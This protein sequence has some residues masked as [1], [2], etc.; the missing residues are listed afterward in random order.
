MNWFVRWARVAVPCALCLACGVPVDDS[1]YEVVEDPPTPADRV[2]SAFAN[3]SDRCEACLRNSCTHAIDPCVDTPACTEFAECVQKIGSPAAQAACSSQDEDVTLDT[4][5]AFGEMRACW[6]VSCKAACGVGKN[7][8]CLGKYEETQPPRPV[9]LVRQSF[10]NMCTNDRLRGAPVAFCDPTGSCEEPIL[11]DDSGSYTFE[12]PTPNSGGLVGWRGFRSVSG[13]ELGVP[14]RLTRNLPIWSDQVE[15]TSLIAAD[16]AG[17][18]ANDLG[19]TDDS[20]AAL[21]WMH[22]MAV[23]IF[24][25]QATGADGVVLKVTTAPDAAIRYAVTLGS[26]VLYENDSSRTSGEG[27]TLVAGLPT[28]EHEFEAYESTSGTLIG[29]GRVQIGYYLNIF[30]IFP[31]A[32]PAE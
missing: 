21:D 14:Y 20:N 16:C 18:Y 11:T 4:V 26:D 3:G 12:V 24:D 19:E 2:V 28:G 31:E 9:A 5:G 27:L 7:W 30:S 15:S 10:W 13:E 32:V 17:E 22:A 1:K 6:A 8:S 29:R 25:C 23:Q